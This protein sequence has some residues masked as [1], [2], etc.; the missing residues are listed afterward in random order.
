MS[1]CYNKHLHFPEEFG[2]WFQFELTSRKSIS[3]QDLTIMQILK[4]QHSFLR[5]FILTQYVG[6]IS[7]NKED[8]SFR[9]TTVLAARNKVCLTLLADLYTPYCPKVL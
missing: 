8:T 6:H 9:Q 7:P 3:F 5:I 2:N 1:L 4:F